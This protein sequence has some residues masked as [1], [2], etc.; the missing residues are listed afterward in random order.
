MVEV[1]LVHEMLHYH[2]LR[3]QESS[4]VAIEHLSLKVLTEICL[5]ELWRSEICLAEYWFVF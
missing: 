2:H 5:E 1:S 4:E 3:C